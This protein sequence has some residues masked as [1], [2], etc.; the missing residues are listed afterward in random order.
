MPYGIN[1][2]VAANVPTCA[3]AI[4]PSVYFMAVRCQSYEEAYDKW[5]RKIEHLLPIPLV[6]P[7]KREGKH[8]QWVPNTTGQYSQGRTDLADYSHRAT[9]QTRSVEGF[10][11]GAVK[12]SPIMGKTSP[13]ASG[14]RRIPKQYVCRGCG[15][16]ERRAWMAAG[17]TMRLVTDHSKC[18]KRAASTPV[19][20]RKAGMAKRKAKRK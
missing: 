1:A 17:N 15:R 5:L 9:E 10:S 8:Q 7:W 20:G 19:L 16:D 13:L 2:A 4:S 18:R 11:A 12:A 14:I 6:K 3:K